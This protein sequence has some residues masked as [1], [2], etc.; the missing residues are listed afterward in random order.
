[1][2]DDLDMKMVTTVFQKT[3]MQT[4]YKTLQPPFKTNFFFLF[5]NIGYS[6]TG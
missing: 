6:K 1:M 3:I 2:V 4:D 5:F